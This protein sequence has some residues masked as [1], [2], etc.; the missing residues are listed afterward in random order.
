[1]NI[2]GC[3]FFR[4]NLLYFLLFKKFIFYASGWV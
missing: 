1:L 3:I 4:S 2:L